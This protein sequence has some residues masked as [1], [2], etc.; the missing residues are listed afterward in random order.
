MSSVGVAALQ[1]GGN[2]RVL[3]ALHRHVFEMHQMLRQVHASVVIVGL[4]EILHSVILC[5]RS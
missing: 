1:I 3:A 5:S 4:H 2:V